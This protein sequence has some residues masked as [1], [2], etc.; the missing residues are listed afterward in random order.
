MYRL[1]K[2]ASVTIQHITAG[3]KIL[4]GRAYLEEH[5]SREALTSVLS[6][7][8]KSPRRDGKHL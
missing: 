3:C 4:A 5:I 8:W 7:S 1:S 2:D 6:I